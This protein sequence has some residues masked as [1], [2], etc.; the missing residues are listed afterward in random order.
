MPRLGYLSGAPRVSTRPDAEATGPRAHVIG[1]MD[2]FR[3]RGW[4]VEPFIVGDRGP[5]TWTRAGVWQQ[6]E[7]SWMRRAGADLVRLALARR[8]EHRASRL[9]GSSVDFVYERFG[10][11]QTLGRAFQHLGVP[12]ILETNG[13]FFRESATDRKSI[14]M[15]GVARRR[16]IL[17]YRRADAVIAITSAL[18]RTIVDVAGIDPDKV[19]VVPN[20]VDVNVFQPACEARRHFA[21][22]TI[23]FVGSLIRYQALDLLFEAVADARRAGMDWHVAIA[24]DGVMREAWSTRASELGL[25]GR[26]A[27]LGP[28]PWSDVPAAIQG[29]DICYSGQ[30]TTEMGVM[31]HS[32]LKLYEYMATG[33]PTIAAAYED[34]ARLVEDGST[35]FLFEPGS[36]VALRGA[37][38]R[39]WLTREKWP[40]MGA[41]ARDRIVAEHSWDVRIEAMLRALAPI[42]P[43]RVSV[44]S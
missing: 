35:G 22:P 37:L 9:L 13:A 32:P 4:T 38:E 27:F 40:V 11:F 5:Q 12:W 25:G 36:A 26:V 34:A 30:I 23:V 20:G 8:N 41:R 39:A 31:Y 16:E 21:E 6:L 33:R 15:T 10:A 7:R 17:A 44:A 2:A 1:V 24:G 28:L 43:S 42:L 3:R 14:L 29:G 19:I 18:K